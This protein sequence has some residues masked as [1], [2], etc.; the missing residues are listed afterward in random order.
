MAGRLISVRLDDAAAAAL[1]VLT[2]GGVSRSQAIR[3]ALIERAARR[4]GHLLAA[5]AAAVAADE[6]DRREAEDVLS[7]MEALR[8]PG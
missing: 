4:D 8:A 7:L 6:D 5:E 1:D 3:E 2:R